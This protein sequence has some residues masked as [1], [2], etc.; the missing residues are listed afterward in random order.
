VSFDGLP[1]DSHV[2]SEWSWDAVAGSMERTCER[3]HDLG[4]PGLAFT[5]HFDLTRWTVPPVVRA[6][7]KVFG[8]LV[9]DDGRFN[10]PSLDIDGYFAALERCRDRFPDLRIM[11]GVEL[12]EPH[13]FREEVHDLLAGGDF[14]RVLGS[15]HSVVVD[16][17][18]WIV[19]ALE[20][21]KA[22]PGWSPADVVRAYLLETA[23]M[24]RSSDDFLI[25]TH[26]DYPVR[27]WPGGPARFPYL[28]FEE[29]F[30]TV[31]SALATTERVFE[32][33]TYI[34]M[35]FDVVRWWREI[36]G[37]RVSFGSDAHRP[38]DVARNFKQVAAMVESAGFRPTSGPYEFWSA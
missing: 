22:P 10:P 33:N 38:E 11:S 18:P 7:M 9:G 20:G 25:L 23:Q 13:W 30:R 32:V 12:G 26:I 2:H 3:A 6:E 5:E 4:L 27:H 36:G 37:Q 31:L 17:R 15:Q 16:G 21:P 24:I 28:E 8:H 1:A 34:P 29:E 35:S 14:H 19:D